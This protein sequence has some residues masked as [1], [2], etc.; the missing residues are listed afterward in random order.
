VD[1]WIKPEKVVCIVDTSGGGTD[2]TTWTIGAE[3]LGRVFGL[4]QG[5]STEGHTKGTLKALAAD[6]KKWGVQTIEI[7]ANFG[8]EMFGELLRPVC[9]EMFYEPEIVSLPAKQVQKEV[10]IVENLEPLASSH[11]LV[12]NAELLRRDFHVDYEDVEAAKRR[13][14]RFTY[15]FSRMTKAKG[16][17]PHDDRVEGFWAGG[18]LRRDAAKALARRCRAG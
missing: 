11:R 6:C 13:Y 8:G 1:A 7:E 15:Q 12:V 16:A 9:A 5:A 18:P 17:V 4:W 3:L 14:Y 2:E 10:R